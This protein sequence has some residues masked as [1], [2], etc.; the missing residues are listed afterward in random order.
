M[1]N[2]NRRD[3]IYLFG[4]PKQFAKVLFAL[5]LFFALLPLVPRDYGLKFNSKQDSQQTENII[6]NGRDR[7]SPSVN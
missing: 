7:C 5:W 1:T 3:Q 4:P 2:S 6:G